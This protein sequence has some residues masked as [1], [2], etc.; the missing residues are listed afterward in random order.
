MHVYIVTCVAVG[1]IRSRCGTSI[2][3]NL[4]GILYSHFTIL[5]Y[6]A[7]HCTVLHYTVL[8]CTILYCTILYCTILYC[9]ILHCTILHCTVLYCTCTATSGHFVVSGITTST[10]QFLR[11]VL[12]RFE[13]TPYIAVV[14]DHCCPGL[15]SWGGKQSKFFDN[16]QRSTDRTTHHVYNWCPRP[17]PCPKVLA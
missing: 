3:V 17:R 5:H 1:R 6:T 15:L 14:L 13:S 11:V 8:H 12:S 9:T 2:L 7:M 16:V 4:W 10:I